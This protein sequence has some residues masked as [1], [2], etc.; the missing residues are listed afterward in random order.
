[1]TTGRINQVATRKNVAGERRTPAVGMRRHLPRPSRPAGAFTRLHHRAG[2]PYRVTAP[3]R[4]EQCRGRTGANDG[5]RREPLSVPHARRGETRDCTAPVTG[6]PYRVLAPG[7]G[8]AAPL[9]AK[10]R[11]PRTSLVP[12]Q[13]EQARLHH[14]AG[15]PYR[16]LAPG[17][18]AAHH[19]GRGQ[20]GRRALARR[21]R[22]SPTP[23]V[24]GEVE[25]NATAPP[26]GWPFRVLAPGHGEQRLLL[27]N[28]SGPL[29]EFGGG[30]TLQQVSH[31]ALRSRPVSGTAFR[32][33]RI[34]W[35]G[36]DGPLP[37]SHGQELQCI[38][39]NSLLASEGSRPHKGDPRARSALRLIK[40]TSSPGAVVRDHQNTTTRHC[41]LHLNVQH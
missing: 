1:M 30:Q 31:L 37:L 40:P 28:T 7:R 19:Q 15:W 6:R 29:S 39:H 13:V 8:A 5:Q 4:G 25:G 26:P 2:W 38:L 18:G 23:L 17:H 22:Q 10:E 20:A 27:L 34:W 35:R 36:H 12:G 21:H 41:A 16:V 14:R 33:K 32:V 11:L 24:P 9:V 3:G